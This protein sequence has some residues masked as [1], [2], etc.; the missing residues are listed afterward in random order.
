MEGNSSRKRIVL[1]VEDDDASA[2]CLSL[3]LKEEDAD[4]DVLCV[5]DGEEAVLFLTRTAFSRMPPVPM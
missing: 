4:V 2:Y 3:A 1:Y 5:S